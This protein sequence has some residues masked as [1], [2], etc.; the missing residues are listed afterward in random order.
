MTSTS[1]S[2]S[3][4]HGRRR[5]GSWRT[6]DVVVAAVI[7]VAFGVVFWAWGLLYAAT[8]GAFAFFPPLK[9]LYAGVWLIPGVLGAW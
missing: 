2:T 9:G 6:V 3:G 5:P 1:T 7:A 8:E 4:T